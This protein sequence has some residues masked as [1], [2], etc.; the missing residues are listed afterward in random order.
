LQV[1]INRDFDVIKE[2]FEAGITIAFG[3]LFGS[4]SK[5]G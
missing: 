3:G 4:V 1:G 5:F 2:G